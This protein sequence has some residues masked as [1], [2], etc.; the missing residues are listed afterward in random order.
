MKRRDFSL[1]CGATLAGAAFVQSTALAQGKPPE[2]GTDYL[3]VEKRAAVEAPAGKIE[4]VEFFWYSCPHCNVFEPTFEAWSKG[5][6]K[7]VVVRRVP[8]AFQDSF[9]PQQRLFY[10]LEAMGLVDKLHAKVFAAI[11]VEKQDLTKAE[12]IADWVAKQ[13]VDK[14]KFL[15]QYNSFSVATKATRGTQLQN[16]YKV[17]GVPALGVAGRFYTDGDH[18]KSMEHALQVVEFLTA[19]VRSGR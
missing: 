2:A 9:V 12:A 8:V 6:P 5:V 16:A 11:H 17:E 7:D 15:A 4:V 13:G 18:A 14:A 3:V 1:T 10:A 19:R